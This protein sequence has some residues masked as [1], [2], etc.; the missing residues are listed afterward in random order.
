MIKECGL[1]GRVAQRLREWG[2][3]EDESKKEEGDRAKCRCA[4]STTL[5]RML[6]RL[7]RTPANRSCPCERLFRRRCDVEEPHWLRMDRSEASHS[8][9]GA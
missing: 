7:G 9:Y 8:W 5:T 6:E 2:K 4:A 3:E 1:V